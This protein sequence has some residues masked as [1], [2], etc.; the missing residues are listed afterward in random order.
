MSSIDSTGGS[1]DGIEPDDDLLAAEYVLGVLDASERRVVQTRMASDAQLA[2]RVE[3]WEHR[4]ATWA[5]SIEPVASPS[6]VWPQIRARLGW[7]APAAKASGLWQSLAFWRATTAAMAAV[8][9]AVL[10]IITLRPPSPAPA[11][12][13]NAPITTLASGSGMPAW[14]AAIDATRGAL[15]LS[16]APNAPAA[17]GRVA[18]LWLIPAGRAPLAVALLTADRSSTLTLPAALRA[19]LRP[20]V[21]L[22]VTLEPPGGAP[23]GAPTGPVVAQGMV[24]L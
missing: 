9:V 2:R 17:Q 23:N 24:Q 7:N 3:S 16:P 14:L 19:Q 20:G 15:Q 6:A 5:L 11:T 13:A 21:V 22:A 18:E 1:D 12:F 4:L 10:L 8:A